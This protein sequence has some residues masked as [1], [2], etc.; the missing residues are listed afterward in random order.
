MASE[1]LKRIPALVETLFESIADETD[2]ELVDVELKTFHGGLHIIVYIDKPAGISLDDCEL[3]NRL[4]GELLDED[5]PIESS[6][7]LE[8]SSPGLERT[9]K[10]KE[11]F[12]KFR[13][14]QVKVKTFQKIEG[15]KNFRGVLLELDEDHLVLR[16]EDGAEKRIALEAISKAQLWEK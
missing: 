3:V 1:K 6:Y 7:M 16:L 9:L 13:G 14:R 8:V 4:L 15:Q 5:D 12:L 10:K 11:D 2:V